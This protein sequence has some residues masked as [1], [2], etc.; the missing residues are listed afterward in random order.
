[1]MWRVRNDNGNYFPSV[2]GD[3]HGEA[4]LHAQGIQIF[5]FKQVLSRNLI[6]WNTSGN[7]IHA[8]DNINRIND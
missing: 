1:M 8:K 3:L 2:V 7:A 4:F 5:L 6:F